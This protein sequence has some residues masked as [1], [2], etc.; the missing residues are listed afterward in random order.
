MV[1]R[2]KIE[3]FCERVVDE[4]H[5]EKVILFGSHAYGTPGPD[6][7]VDILVIMPYEGH[8]A[9][10]ASAIRSRI[11]AGFPLDLLIRTQAQVDE[12]V[13]LNDFFMRDIT[14]KGQTLYDAADRRVGVKGRRSS[15]HRPARTTS[16]QR[17]KS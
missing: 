13:A 4:F 8:P 2:A 5:P 1:D 7:D 17:A 15:R 16:A 10:K 9:Y 11:R 14:E 12:R 6:S 3:E